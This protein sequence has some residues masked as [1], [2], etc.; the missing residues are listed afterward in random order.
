[1]GSILP[2]DVK[3]RLAKKAREEETR[4]INN[5]RK[6][7]TMQIWDLYIHTFRDSKTWRQEGDITQHYD[8]ALRGE[9]PSANYKYFISTDHIGSIT[10][11]ETYKMYTERGIDGCTQDYFRIKYSLD[12]NISFGA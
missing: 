5:N 2:Q 4:K 1:M 12:P 10:A 11:D 9:S 7:V 3:D 6:Q 8:I